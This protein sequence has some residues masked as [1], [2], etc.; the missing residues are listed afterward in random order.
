M[1]MM[2]ILMN[3]AMIHLINKEKKDM[4]KKILFLF[5]IPL[6]LLYTKEI[7]KFKR[8]YDVRLKVEMIVEREDGFVQNEEFAI[9]LAELYLINFYG[10]SIKRKLPLKA[11][12]E[13]DIWY[14]SGT[15]PEGYEGGVPVIKISKKS[16]AILGYINQK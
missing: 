10:E 14:I 13:D 15:L 1:K 16:G 8:E 6:S 11:K 3:I 9:K 2:Q 5:I 7:I 12:L 4:V